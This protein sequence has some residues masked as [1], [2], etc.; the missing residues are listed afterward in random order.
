MKYLAFTY[1]PQEKVRQDC[2]NELILTEEAYLNDMTNVHKIFEVPLR[3]SNAATEDEIQGIFVNWQEIIQC[4]RRFLGDLFNRRD[5]GSTN[6]GDVL[7][8]HVR[9]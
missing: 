7:C 8:N 6:I 5:S 9:N 1:D 2:I 4:N 3:M